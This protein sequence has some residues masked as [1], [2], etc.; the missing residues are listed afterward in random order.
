[1]SFNINNPVVTATVLSG[2]TVSSSI[3][4]NGA[5]LGGLIFPAALTS[6]A[7]TFQV[8]TDNNTFTALYTTAG[9][10]VSI[11]VAA[12]RAVPLVWDTFA[13]WR[14]VQLVMGSAEGADRAIIAIGRTT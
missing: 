9:A 11:T 4:L 2:Q 3:D 10:A 7:V 8:S 1:M 5:A 14:Y 12:S 6:T 13:P